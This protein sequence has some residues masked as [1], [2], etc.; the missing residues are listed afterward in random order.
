MKRGFRRGGH[1]TDSTQKEIIAG[2]RKVTVVVN[3]SQASTKGCPDVVARH[4]AWYPVWLEIK[5]PK[6]PVTDAQNAFALQWAGYHRV[7]RTLD[8]AMVAL[9]FA[10]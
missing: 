7:V 4:K 9:G 3:L 2:L 5:G 1:R 8:E 6:T 10:P